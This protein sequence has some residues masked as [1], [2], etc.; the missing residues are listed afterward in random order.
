MR[1]AQGIRGSRVAW[2]AVAIIGTVL[3]LSTAGAQTTTEER[4]VR[5]RGVSEVEAVLN[6][7]QEATFQVCGVQINAALNTD[8]TLIEGR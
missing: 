1:T 5:G 7:L 3:A 8:S 4:E 6:A 2:A